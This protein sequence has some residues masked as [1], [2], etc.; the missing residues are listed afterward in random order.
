VAKTKT[1]DEILKELRG[2]ERAVKGLA[3]VPRAKRAPRPKSPAAPKAKVVKHWECQGFVRT[4]CGKN[5][6]VV[7]LVRGKKELKEKHAAMQTDLDREIETAKARETANGKA[8]A[9]AA[10]Q[11]AEA[12]AKKAADEKAAELAK[13]DAG[14]DKK[15]RKEQATKAKRA[16]GT[17]KP[18][19]YP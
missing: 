6:A 19:K 1:A 17:K 11:A 16:P 12:A 3:A 2:Q 18:R 10:H 15:K 13:I 7:D 14:W 5:A 9:E 4:G 8:V